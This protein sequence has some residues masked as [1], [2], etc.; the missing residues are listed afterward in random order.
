MVRSPFWRL[1]EPGSP[2]AGYAVAG[3]D[4]ARVAGARRRTPPLPVMRL[5]NDAVL[6]PTTGIETVP[7][8]F[9]LQTHVPSREM[10]HMGG[11]D[12]HRCLYPRPMTP[13]EETVRPVHRDEGAWTALPSRRMPMAI[14]GRAP[15][16]CLGPR[17]PWGRRTAPPREGVSGKLGA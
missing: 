2:G 6:S 8:H 13:R 12:G 4:A 9:P 16:W 7:D 10:G 15:D 11:A 1:T 17:V 5:D 3:T 14:P